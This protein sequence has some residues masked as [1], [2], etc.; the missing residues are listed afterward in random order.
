[1]I[2]IDHETLAVSRLATQ[3]REST[4]LITYIKTLLLEAND[5]EEV[6]RQLLEDRWIDT[7]EGIQ[8]DILGSIVGQP[9]EILGEE[10]LGYFGFAINFESGS[11][12]SILNPSI[13]GVFRSNS[14]P[15]TENRVLSDPEY[16]VWIRARI[17][18]NS[19]SSTPEDIINQIMFV[20]GANQVIFIDGN[21]E[22][23]VSVGKVLTN[24]EK[25]ILLN[26]DIIPKTAGVQVKYLTQ[27]NY[28]SFF[29]F[30]GIPNSAGLGS[31]SDP[32][33]GGAFG[34]LII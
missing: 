27:Y 12:G 19:T 21:T 33:L 6:F 30:E 5:L 3:F 1:M 17:A 9:R 16:R 7:A 8:L 20:I 28:E 31:V 26:T 29:G 15:V 22:Y 11:L 34:Q 14:E 24:E 4:N 18:K 25:S 2:T 23:S 32:S 10:I 13:G